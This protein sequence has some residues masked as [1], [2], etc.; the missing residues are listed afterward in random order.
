MRNKRPKCK[1]TQGQDFEDIKD[2]EHSLDF[3]MK[4]KKLYINKRCH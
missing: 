2:E 1:L 4:T 3:D